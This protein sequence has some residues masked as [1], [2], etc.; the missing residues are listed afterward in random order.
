MDDFFT[1][2]KENNVPFITSWLS[3]TENDINCCDHHGFTAIHWCCRQNNLSLFEMFESRGSSCNVR[4]H[5]GDTPLH[6][7]VSHSSYEIVKKLLKLKVPLDIPNIHGNTPI[8]YA[9]F[10]NDLR[11]IELLLQHGASPSMCNRSMK[12]PFDVCIPS[13]IPK[14][15]TLANDYGFSLEAIPFCEDSMDDVPLADELGSLKLRQFLDINE[16][17]LVECHKINHLGELWQGYW[18]D[19][20]I[21]LKKIYV[22][23]EHKRLNLIFQEQYN[24]LRIFSNP[25]VLPVSAAIVVDDDVRLVAQWM[26]Y[27]SLYNIL[28]DSS[29]I[30]IDQKKVINFAIDICRGMVYL[31]SL[32]PLVPFLS[33]SSKHIL[34]GHDLKAKISM[35]SVSTSIQDHTKITSPQWYSPEILIK[36][37]M[38]VD[39]RSS[40]IWS[41]GIIL[42]EMAGREIPFNDLSAMEIGMKI[43]LQNI[44]PNISP[45]MPNVLIKFMKLCWNLEP[46]KRPR[47]DQLL[48]ILLKIA[49]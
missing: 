3:D 28:H 20:P 41:F 18:N 9:F 17:T 34:I 14:I 16:V 40:D 32:E 27:G 46:N 4:N 37:Y 49:S 29:G 25:N 35:L 6:L 42:W 38:N 39:C 7:A 8:H 44:R 23:G 48:P 31:H 22:Y 19:I 33:L 13:L 12:A 5:G 45:G 26:P 15:K 21:A 36:G 1:A 10:W 11:M 2:I 24:R 43:A 30:V 47:F